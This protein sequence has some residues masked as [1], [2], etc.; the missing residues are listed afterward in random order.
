MK[1]F[2]LRKDLNQ[3]GQTKTRRGTK[4]RIKIKPQYVLVLKGG[5]RGENKSVNHFESFQMSSTKKD[6]MLP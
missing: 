1:V 6:R 4:R 3:C 5:P 2:N